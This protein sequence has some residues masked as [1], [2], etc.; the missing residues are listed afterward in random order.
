M[1]QAQ[2]EIPK[3]EW[4]NREQAAAWFA[5]QGVPTLTERKLRR[6]AEAGEG[7][8]VYKE[9]RT[10]YYKLAELPGWLREHWM[11][12]DRTGRTATAA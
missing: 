2:Q 9:G 12:P 4:V 6:M 8:T 3:T 10:P 11:Q 5:S 1:A 7:P